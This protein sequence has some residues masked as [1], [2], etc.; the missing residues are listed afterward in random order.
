MLSPTELANTVTSFATLFAGWFPVLLT[1]LVRPHQPNRWLF[2][3]IT[4]LITGIP[5]IWYHG[6]GENYSLRLADTG[7]NLIVGWALVNAV[8]GDFYRSS[9]KIK[10]LWPVTVLNLTGIGSMVY[11]ISLRDDLFRIG[12]FFPGELVLV[13]DGVLTVGLLI[14]NYQNM[15][16]KARPLLLIVALTFLAGAY[17]ASAGGHNVSLQIIAEHALWH[18]AGAF[19]FMTMWAMNH[20]RFSEAK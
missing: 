13:F 1:L 18:I 12:G 16:A 11:E 4:V 19:G 17:L 20:I 8:L 6:F 15:L 10:W 3:Y 5:T 9:I 7:S 14:A 2:V